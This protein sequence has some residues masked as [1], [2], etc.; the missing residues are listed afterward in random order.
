MEV[1]YA[2]YGSALPFAEPIAKLVG[3]FSKIDVGAWET[4]IPQHFTIV[5]GVRAGVG[6]RGH[7][8]MVIDASK[9]RGQSSKG[10]AKPR[11][12]QEFESVHTRLRRLD[13]V[14][15]AGD[16]E[17]AEPGHRLEVGFALALVA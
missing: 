4:C 3:T 9:G 10:R 6:S 2:T 7:P 17:V 15:T 16:N 5:G 8:Q 13:F 1:A 11:L 14:P 12:A